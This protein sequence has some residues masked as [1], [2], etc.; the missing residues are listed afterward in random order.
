L[1]SVAT[2]VRSAIVGLQLGHMNEPSTL[3]PAGHVHVPALPAQ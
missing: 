3:V 2:F 1:H